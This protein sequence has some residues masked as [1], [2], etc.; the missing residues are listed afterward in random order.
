MHF[1]FA[2]LFEE[3]QRKNDSANFNI[4]LY[5]SL[6]YLLLLFAIYLPISEVLDKIY[7]DSVLTY[8]KS[9]LT[10][11]I[12]AILAAVVYCVYYR[13]IKK[14]LIITLTK[15]YINRKIN[16]GLLYALVVL[17]PLLFLIIGVTATVLL[18][19]GTILDHHF[20]GLF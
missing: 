17:F 4:T 10:A 9:I 14:G 3:Y 20:K 19:G 18:K 8:N 13:Y 15:K 16:R 2:K 1:F 5:I 6:F 7:W 11:V 12:F